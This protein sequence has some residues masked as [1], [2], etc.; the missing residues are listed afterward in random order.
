[1]SPQ[2]I[3]AEP[4]RVVFCTYPSIYSTIVLYELIQS[5]HI[6]LVGVVASTRIFRKKGWSWWDVMLLLRRTGLRY[7]AYLWMITSL[8]TLLR[9]FGQQNQVEEYLARN[10]TPVLHSRDINSAKGTD[11]VKACKPDMMLSA[12]FNQL[13][14]QKLLAMPPKGCLNI[15]PGKLPEYKGVDPVIYALASREQQ[16]GVTVHF[17]DKDFDTGPVVVSGNIAVQDKDSLLSL[18]RKLFRLGIGLL[19]D[20]IATTG[21]IPNGVPQK[22]SDRHDSWP[23]SALVAKVR[24]NGSKLITWHLW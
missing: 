1:M 9:H 3:T 19:L 17:Q 13:I 20:K 4:L 2:P 23:D 8:Y 22:A 16:L 10:R 14:G 7:A 15:H 18:N 24:K 21:G 5:P 12:H 11:F 6:K